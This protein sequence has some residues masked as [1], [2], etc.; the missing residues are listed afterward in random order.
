MAN[1]FGSLSFN[2]PYTHLPITQSF[3]NDLD[4][5]NGFVAQPTGYTF[6][7]ITKSRLSELALYGG[8]YPTSVNMSETITTTNNVTI[9]GTGYTIGN[10]SYLDATDGTTY[11][12]GSVPNFFAD[13]P[14][15]GYIT[16]NTTGYVTEYV[17]NNMLTRNEHFLGFV[18][19]PTIY[20]DVFIERGKQGVLEN[21]LRLSEIENTGELEIYGNKFFKIKKQ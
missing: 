13:L 2:I 1:Y 10:L 5:G 15:T 16:G 12:F 6:V 8:G 17:I 21:N 9:N 20:S 4:F 3:D 7:A 14:P 18:E 11:V 19:E